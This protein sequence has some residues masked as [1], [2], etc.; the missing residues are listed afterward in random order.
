VFLTSVNCGLFCVHVQH[1]AKE[2]MSTIAR[3]KQSA[4]S[5]PWSQQKNYQAALYLLL[6]LFMVC[7]CL[8]ALLLVA[9][10]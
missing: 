1:S 3:E 9:I 2:Y 5:M 6:F 4:K 10:L 8:L 7:Y